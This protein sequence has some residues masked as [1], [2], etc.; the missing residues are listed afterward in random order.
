MFSYDGDDLEFLENEI[1]SF[2]YSTRRMEML[3]GERYYLGQHDVLGKKRTVIGGGGELEEVGNL[4]NNRVVD[5]QYKKMIDQKNNYLLGQPVCFR[6][7][8][9][10]YSRLLKKIFSRKFLKTLKNV[11]EDCLIYGIG[12]LFPCYIDGEF[13]FKRF[14]G[15][16]VIPGWKDM[17]H[18]KLEYVIRLYDQVECCGK[19]RKIN[20]FAEVYDQ[21]GI[22]YFSLDGGKLVPEPPYES[23]Y[24][25]IGDDGYNWGKIPFIPF[26]YN[27]NETGVLRNCKSLQDG[28]N[29]IISN[30]ANQMEEDVRNTIFVLVNYDGENLGEFRKN[31]STYGA[32]KVKTVDGANGDLKTLQ[33]AVN[34]ENYLAIIKLF[35][36]GIIENAMG[37]DGKD[38]RLGGNA[39]Q[40]NIKSMYSDIDLD[41]NNMETEFQASMEELLWFVNVHFHN[42][43]KCEKDWFNDQSVE[44]IFNR[45]MLIN[46]TEVIDNCIKSV[47]VLSSDTVIAN[48]PWVDDLEKEVGSIAFDKKLCDKN[49]SSL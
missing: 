18:T 2:K 9:V 22:R 32:V 3:D 8:E 30:F 38:D 48:H 5:N 17:E 35:K 36:Q 41:A 28:L 27:N 34:S 19:S 16:D 7:D 42:I 4:V 46:E 26:R 10:E 43:A 33:V 24:F 11:G 15:R 23:C 37:Y 44:F 39:N 25:S 49:S 45:D 40:L 6:C 29:T 31:L 14:K 13:M 1:S 20:Q 21:N 12:W 47:G